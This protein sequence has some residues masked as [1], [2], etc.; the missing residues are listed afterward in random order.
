MLWPLEFLCN[1]ISLYSTLQEALFSNRQTPQPSRPTSIYSPW[2]SHLL[3]SSWVYTVPKVHRQHGSRF[4]AYCTKDIIS[5]WAFPLDSGKLFFRPWWGTLL[6]NSPREF[7]EVCIPELTPCYTYLRAVLKTF[8]HRVLSP[9]LHYASSVPG[10]LS[11]VSL[12][13]LM[14]YC[15]CY[16]CW[17]TFHIHPTALP[18]LF[19]F[20]KFQ[21]KCPF[22]W[23]DFPVEAWC[24]GN[25]SS[26]SL[27][28]L[29]R[30]GPLNLSGFVTQKK[31]MDVTPNDSGSGHQR[32]L[33][34]YFSCWN[35]FFC[36]LELVNKKPRCFEPSMTTSRHLD[37]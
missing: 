31:A 24:D 10:S 15:C 16:L 27:T 5:R 1:L 37:Q 9:W 2:N 29:W 20:F 14:L 11:V 33:I 36:S 23:N 35:S 3:V 12:V 26:N 4:E 21:A 30:S 17:A 22:L 7:W 25:M 28:F 18:N 8:F 19:F 34:F 13:S 32:T 6:K